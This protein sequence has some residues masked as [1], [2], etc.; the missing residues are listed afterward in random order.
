MD[1]GTKNLR[2]Y[3]NTGIDKYELI[4]TIKA[5]AAEKNVADEIA[6]NK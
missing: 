5:I 6:M 1:R 2:F 4:N 3:K